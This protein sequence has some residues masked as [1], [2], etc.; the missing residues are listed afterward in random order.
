MHLPIGNN[1]LNCSNDNNENDNDDIIELEY[2]E[3]TAK[4]EYY[5]QKN[6]FKNKSKRIFRINYYEF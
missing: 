4:L 6:R 1:D 2:S 5:E 3:R